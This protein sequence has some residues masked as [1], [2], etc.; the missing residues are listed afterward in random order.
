[1]KNLKIFPALI[2]SIAFLQVNA[3]TEI[4]KGFKKG[5]V[6]L[7]DGSNVSGY[8][9]DNIRNNAS[10]TFITEAGEKKKNY[11]GSDLQSAEIEDAKFLCINGDFFRII[12]QGDLCFLQKSSDASGKPSYNGN[13]AVFSNGTEGKPNDY[14]IYNNRNKELK[15][16]SKK[17]F[18][19]VVAKTFAGNTAAI[20][21]AKTANGDVARLKDAVDLYNNRGN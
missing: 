18:D 5:A 13:E 8:I 17:N 16:V 14:F 21:K 12:S 19:E 7:A 20:D 15:L 10:V 11:N 2:I 1:M 3:Q 6:T 9:K 4:P